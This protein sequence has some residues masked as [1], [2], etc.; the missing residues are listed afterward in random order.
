MNCSYPVVE[1]YKTKCDKRRANLTKKKRNR[2]TGN[3]KMLHVWKRGGVK[4]KHI[5]CM[6]QRLLIDWLAISAYLESS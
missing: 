1:E 2:S 3:A 6:N 4:D 5:R